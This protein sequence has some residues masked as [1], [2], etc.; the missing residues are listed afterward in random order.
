MMIRITV[1]EVPGAHGR[2]Y[3]SIFIDG[4][5]IVTI[6]DQLTMLVPV[7]NEHIFPAG[8]KEL[9]WRLLEPRIDGQVIA[10]ILVCGDDCDLYCTVI[11][12]EITYKKDTI[13]WE[14]LDFDVSEHKDMAR[15][16][17]QFG[18]QID[19]IIGIPPMTFDR[20]E[21]THCMLILKNAID[22]APVV[23]RST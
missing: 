1:D 4:R 8:Y 2:P 10:P 17:R 20:E 16:Q 23:R 21:Y 14:R 15:M 7:M 11:V 22:A 13:H 9:A 3:P 6:H 18:L 19:W 5:N 12:A